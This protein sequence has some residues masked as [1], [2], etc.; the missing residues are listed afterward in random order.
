MKQINPWI[1]K[2]DVEDLNTQFWKE[3]IHIETDK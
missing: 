2:W 1:A 3:E